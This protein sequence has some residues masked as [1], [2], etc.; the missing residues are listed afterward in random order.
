ML[1]RKG[2]HITDV[3]TILQIHEAHSYLTMVHTMMMRKGKNYSDEDPWTYNAMIHA[4]A[5]R[6]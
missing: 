3:M 1:S 2:T 4:W 5:K 6:V